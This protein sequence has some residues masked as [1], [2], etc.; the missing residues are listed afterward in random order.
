MLESAGTMDLSRFCYPWELCNPYCVKKPGLAS[1]RM[2]DASVDSRHPLTSFPP[3][4][5][6]VHLSPSQHSDL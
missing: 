5:M 1:W 3:P 4:T 6:V 2:S